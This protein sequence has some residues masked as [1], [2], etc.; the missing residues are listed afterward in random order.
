[1]ADVK[2]GGGGF[3]SSVAVVHF[4]T[5]S[6]DELHDSD[7]EEATRASFPE[8][9]GLR[10]PTVVLQIIPPFIPERVSDPGSSIFH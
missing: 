10:S 6:A 9:S 8:P 3:M 1:M 5:S 4:I 2:V 7:G